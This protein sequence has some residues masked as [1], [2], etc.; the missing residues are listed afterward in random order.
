M[1]TKLMMV[2]ISQ[3]IPLS[4]HYVVHPELIQCYIYLNKTEGQKFVANVGSC[5]PGADSVI[6]A[7]SILW[8]LH[9][10]TRFPPCQL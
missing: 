4:N 1:L 2:I 9:L 8:L 5:S 7:A 6:W 10:S 3:Y